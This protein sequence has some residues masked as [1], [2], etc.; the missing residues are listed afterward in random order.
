MSPFLSRLTFSCTLSGLLQFQL[1][2][3]QIEYQNKLY[4]INKKDEGT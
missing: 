2:W 3:T 4:I 1:H